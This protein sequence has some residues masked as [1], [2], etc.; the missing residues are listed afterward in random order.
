MSNAMISLDQPASLPAHLQGF[1]SGAAKN[2]VVGGPSYNRIGLKGNRFRLVIN[3][4]E[5]LIVED[6]H[7]DVIIVGASP[8]VSRLLYLKAFAPGEKAPPDCYSADGVVPNA[9][10]KNPQSVKCQTCPQNVIGSRVT[11]DGKKTRACGY[12]KRLAV[13]LPSAPDV[14]YRLDCKGMTIFGSGAPGTNKFSLAE[15]GKKLSARGVDPSWLITR[16]SFDT[17]ESVPKVLFMPTQYL[18]AQTAPLIADLINSDMIGRIIEITSQTVDVSA[19]TASAESDDAPVAAQAAATINPAPVAA[20]VA[21][22]APAPVPAPTVAAPAVARPAA[23]AVTQVARP[24]AP[25][26]VRTVI[27]TAP[28]PVAAPAVAKAVPPRTAAAPLEVPT[29]APPATV[30]LEGTVV[31]AESDD[32]EL[33]ALIARMEA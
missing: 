16:L 2:L 18:D 3:G 4:Q 11:Q 28:A 32:A 1:Q 22:P 26:V 8:N 12:F 24:A 10:V 17:E 25:V 19:E 23:P 14:L 21:T 15:Y 13:V 33:A 6:N 9:D 20:P 7:L 30:V 27:A 5:E 29:H 31:A